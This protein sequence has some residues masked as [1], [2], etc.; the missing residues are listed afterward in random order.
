MNN[1]IEQTFKELNLENWQFINPINNE[2][3]Q[4]KVAIVKNTS[5]GDVGAFRI[6]KKTDEKSIQ[7]FQRDVNIITN[8]EFHH[9][10]VIKLLDFNIHR[11]WY[12]SEIGTDFRDYWKK[13]LK[14]HQPDGY[15]EIAFDI[16]SKLASG[17][18]KLHFKGVVHRDIKPANLIIIEDEPVLIDFG[19]AFDNNE[20]RITDINSAVGNVRFSPDQMM[21][22]QDEVLPWLDI[23]ELSQLFI[24]LVNLNPTKSWNRPLDWRWVI[25][26]P[27]LS[28]ENV[29]FM[30]ALTAICS[31]PIH[32]PQNA[33]DFITLMNNLK[34]TPNNINENKDIQEIIKK[35]KS[36]E[37]RE[38]T[39]NTEDFEAYTIS[40]PLLEKF[41]NEINQFI[42]LI[43]EDLNKK[44]LPIEILKTPNFYDKHDS[45][46]K[47]PIFNGY[48]S[49][50]IFDV[51]CGKEEKH[52][53]VRCDAHF[54]TPS[55]C[56]TH[57]NTDFM[58][59]SFFPLNIVLNIG[60]K[61]KSEN[62]Y[63][64]F[65][66]NADLFFNNDVRDFKHNSKK[67][68]IEGIS[69]KIEDYMTN[70]DHWNSVFS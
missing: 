61:N 32:C 36:S 2:S 5:N 28:N 70:K 27:E 16:I 41:Y 42:T 69:K 25:Y 7:R 45:I 14:T 15:F 47:N 58:D 35:I 29:L 68:S 57:N 67:T 60:L 10:N 52:F 43:I 23:F 24:W 46:L 12:I 39:L 30:R 17:L 33:K 40:F 49:F 50:F 38:L 55:F 13:K 9:K 34:H 1:S 19:L 54:M 63:L 31:N 20:E 65:D 51:R 21:Y 53:Q 11:Y 8:K 6:L 37:A 3:G 26:P 59:P 22:K 66:K 18:I 4:A 56:R 48:V 62:T 64:Q 44:G